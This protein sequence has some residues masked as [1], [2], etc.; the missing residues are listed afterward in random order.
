MHAQVAE[1]LAKICN[2]LTVDGIVCQGFT[3]DGKVVMFKGQSPNTYI[4]IK[5]DACNSPGQEATFWGLNAGEGPANQLAIIL[6][7][8]KYCT[9]RAE[10][11]FCTLHM[12]Y[13]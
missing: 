12:Q 9:N 2:G 7:D 5:Y 8:V 4:D 3:Y 10:M 6:C 11:L 13:P 1:D